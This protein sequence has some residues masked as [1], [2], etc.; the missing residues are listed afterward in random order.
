MYDVCN[1]FSCYF[2]IFLIRSMQIE[3]IEKRKNK[4][5]NWNFYRD[6]QTIYSKLEEIR[7][8]Y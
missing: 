1:F 5:Q 6:G 4:K 3:K 8:E 7:S 2:N